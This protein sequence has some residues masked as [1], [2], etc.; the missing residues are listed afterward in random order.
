MS[1]D[2]RI[3]A[4]FRKR[5][6]ESL[7]EAERAMRSHLARE[8]RT[9][10]GILARLARQ[11]YGERLEAFRRKNPRPLN[12]WT[13]SDWQVF[14]EGAAEDAP[15]YGWGGSPVPQAT[16]SNGGRRK[17]N[18][19]GNSRHA[20]AVDLNALKAAIKQELLRELRPRQPVVLR[21]RTAAEAASPPAEATDFRPGITGR[22]HPQARGTSV[23]PEI[24]LAEFKSPLL[25]LKFDDLQARFGGLRWR[26]A[27]MI[28][29]L[30]STYGLN[31][32]IELGR[33]IGKTEGFAPHSNSVKAP[34]KQLGELGL[35]HVESLKID[36]QKRGFALLLGRLTD[37]GR[38]FCQAVGWQPVESEWERLVRLHEGERQREH[39]LAVLYFALMSR[40]R[41]Y[42]VTV[43]PETRAGSTP[44]DVLLERDGERVLVEVELGRHERT[45]KWQ[46]LQ[47]AQGFAA[48]CTLYPEERE[49]LVNDCKLAHIP[50]RATDLETLRSIKLGREIS[51]APLWA[52]EWM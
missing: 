7:L 6:L 18:G 39:T 38:E 1:N 9:F 21:P 46:N 47:A 26:R 11:H 29:Y 8:N 34:F 30:I 23:P 32:L 20:E 19:N 31:A 36:H 50:G 22:R 12:E 16:G 10:S 24:S 13:A 17:G 40:A 14:F 25:P 5:S 35:L 37:T 44:P 45:T 15:A 42:T 48:V 2:E 52:E 51:P 27:V 28:L 41:G 43:L 3:A 49:R 33:H 4:A